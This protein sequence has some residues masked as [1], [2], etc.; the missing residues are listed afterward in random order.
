MLLGFQKRFADAVAWGS[1]TQTIRRMPKRK[2]RIGETAHCFAGLRT[3]KC[4]LLGRWVIT[5]V[6][7]IHI[8]EE[9]LIMI[10]GQVVEFPLKLSWADGFGNDDQMIDWFRATHGLPFSGILVKWDY[11]QDRLTKS[12][13]EGLSDE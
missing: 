6:Q 2:P 13:R 3:P 7:D 9:G 12:E 4:R 5:S 10:D 1:K 8:D 11:S